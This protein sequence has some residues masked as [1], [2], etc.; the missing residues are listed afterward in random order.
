MS[1][2]SAAWGFIDE[3]RGW[4][5][6]RVVRHRWAKQLE[7]LQ[8][9]LAQS[10]A[11]ETDLLAMLAQEERRDERRLEK[12]QQKRG[13]AK[14]KA[15]DSRQADGGGTAGAVGDTAEA[16]AAGQEAALL[17]MRGSGS[18]DEG[19]R[20]LACPFAVLSP[21]VTA[22]HAGARLESARCW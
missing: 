18:S 17:A 19:V 21:P 5:F 8:L 10:A 9:Q 16:E 1:H 6:L 13:K 22:I 20:P 7:L 15:A 4:V 12:R 14:R 11:A 2:R 3:R